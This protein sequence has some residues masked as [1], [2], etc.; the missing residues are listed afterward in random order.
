[1]NEAS[2]FPRSAWIAIFAAIRTPRKSVRALSSDKKCFV[3]RCVIP[4]CEY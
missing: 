2:P 4:N 3:F 1:M